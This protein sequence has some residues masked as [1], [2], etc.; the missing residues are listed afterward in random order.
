MLR[1]IFILGFWFLY[2]LSF[3]QTA[4]S[5]YSRV[6]VFLEG[7]PISKL[8][9]LGLDVSH[10]TAKKGFWLDTDLSAEELD[11]VKKDGFKVEILVED[12][13]EHFEQQHQHGN[14]KSLHGL[15]VCNKVKSKT[16]PSGFQLGSM[17]GYFY[18]EEMLAQLDSMHARFP[19]LISARSPIDTTTTHENRP[20]FG[21]KISDNPL[22]DETQEPEALYTAIH[23]AREPGSMSQIIYFMWYLLENYANDSV[24]KALVDNTQLHFVPCLNPDGYIFN[25]TNFPDGGG[26]W[27]KNRRNNGQGDFGVDLNRN[28]GKF[29]GFDDDGS[30]PDES[31][32]TYRGPSAFSEPETRAIKAFCES[33]RF[34]FAMNYHTY[35]NLLIYPW[36]YSGMTTPDAQK[37]IN[38]GKL[39]TRENQYRYGTGMETLG[40]NSNGSSDDWMYGE[41]G[42]KPKIYS[43]TPECGSWFWE[44][45][46]DIIPLCESA[47]EQNISIAKLLLPFAQVEDQS[48]EVFSTRQIHFKYQFRNLSQSASSFRLRVVPLVGISAVG[49]EK[50]YTF[51]E[52]AS[53]PDSISLTINSQSRSGD[54]IG[55]ISELSNGIFTQRDTIWHWYGITSERFSDNFSTS[56]NWIGAWR[57]NTTQGWITDSPNGTYSSYDTVFSVLAN[58]VDLR[59]TNRA[60][61]QFNIRYEIEDLYDF[62]QVLA[63]T[64]SGAT[65]FTLC[66]KLTRPAVPFT[67]RSLLSAPGYDGLQPNWRSESMDLGDL[68]GHRIWLKL[69]L[70]SDEFLEEDG[71]YIRDMKVIALETTTENQLFKESDFV[72]LYPNPA[73]SEVSIKANVPIYQVHAYNAFGKL[74]SRDFSQNQATIQVHT[75]PEGI[76]FLQIQLQDGSFTTKKLLIEKK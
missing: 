7:K 50:T 6:R 32:E 11:R 38:Y 51:N 64:D 1:L 8:A 2:S 22:Q 46:E 76:Y 63:S 4:Q 55:W 75:W 57:V 71:I 23:H 53:V 43:F 56:Q 70:M 36:G 69:L 59:N 65:W 29:W 21:V 41:T 13:L 33:R 15:P 34:A 39:L 9:A 35:S 20:I 14:V 37:F 47:L 26:M 44:P 66:G 40:Y 25:Q 74:I 62:G 19:N 73:N 60:W 31:W 27:R 12:L 58:P 10:G 72:T 67:Q 5:N 16:T 54:A 30:S 24:V 61:L 28:Y 42:T 49:A 3:A 18:Y 68:V 48:P 45:E 52:E 17:S